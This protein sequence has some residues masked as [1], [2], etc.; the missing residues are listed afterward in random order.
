M[1]EAAT[2]Q[3][4]AGVPAADGLVI[5]RIA[6]EGG[7]RLGGRRVGSVAQ[8]CDALLRAIA[9]AKEELAALVA[10]EDELAAGI[11]EFQQAL[12]E[13]DDLL[14]PIFKAIQAGGTA[15]GAWDEALDK[16]IAEYRKGDDEYLSARAEDLSDLKDRVLR[17]LVGKDTGRQATFAEGA[18]LVAEDLTPSRF[19]ELD[20]QRLGGGAIRGGSKTSHVA[21]L[22]R[23]RGIPLI[24]GLDANLEH[25][26]PDAPA[27]LD[28]EAG[29]LILA[30]SD[31]TL[32][33]VQ[34]RILAR[35]AGDEAAAEALGEDAVTAEGARIQV[36]INV[37][38]PAMLDGLS[39]E[40]CDGIGLTRTEF[41]FEG[42]EPPDEDA[43]LAVYRRILAWAG[44]KPV[45]IRTLD[46][47]G[48]KPIPGV[49]LDAESNPF[50]GQRGLRL[51]LARPEV[52][53]V[54][55]RAL[56]RAAA[57]GPLKV[58]LPMVTLPEELE[59]ARRLFDDILAELAA[60]GVAH[61]TPALGIMIEVPAA[62]L[63]AGDFEADFYSIG[64]NDLVQYVMAAARDNPALT[65]LALADHP[66][67]LE[68]IRRSVEAA[69][70]RGVEIGLCGD[71]A[72]D[73]ALVPRLLDCGLRSL[74]V[75]PAQLGRIK[76]ALRAYRGQAASP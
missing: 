45:T 15:H 8:E 1:A 27:V 13:D 47:G 66:A 11:L 71:L 63:T 12:L 56:A 39:A 28:A 75:A 33:Q 67:V 40:H 2:E 3:V 50:L 4:I 18:I 24:V 46:A 51:S 14:A 25:L 34:S 68:L 5:G 65:G 44:G 17:A 26:A 6:R 9:L 64:S 32:A 10:G 62:A 43:Q 30:P 74:S 23:A 48:D 16:E 72:S 54:Q 35:A 59:Q 37:D 20:W 53:R 52:F 42:N 38:D 19:L 61:G 58:M 57:E 49:T 7:L 73:P 21:I 31:G 29:Q 76:L 36:L 60:E 55:L 69:G 70:T 41:L 22:A